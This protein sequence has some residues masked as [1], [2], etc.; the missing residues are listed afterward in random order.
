MLAREDPL[1]TW[2][3]ASSSGS[4]LNIITPFLYLLTALL[5]PSSPS[6]P[7]RFHL[8]FTT[9]HFA[10]FIECLTSVTPV[11][12]SSHV[13]TGWS[14]VQFFF[15]RKDTLWRFSFYI[16][17]PG[18]CSTLGYDSEYFE[19][20]KVVRNL[21]VLEYI[22]SRRKSTS[23]LS[24]QSY[25]QNSSEPPPPLFTKNSWPLLLITGALPETIPILPS[26]RTCE[27]N[28]EGFVGVRCSTKYAKWMVKG[29]QKK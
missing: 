25:L 9:P 20:D 26:V 21:Y 2:I 29:T 14:A 15:K 17:K 5:Y 19:M 8:F 24:V 28:I 1:N 18:V 16:P 12:L 27:K 22:S 6:L 23:D 3:N 7:P 10:S 4:L 11:I 13:L